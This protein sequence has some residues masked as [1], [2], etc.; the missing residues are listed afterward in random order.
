MIIDSKEAFERYETNGRTFMQKKYQ[1]IILEAGGRLPRT[2]SGRSR[3][4]YKTSVLDRLAREDKLGTKAYKAILNL[5]AKK[6]NHKKE[7]L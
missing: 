6:E 7:Q 1:D 5:D 2:G 4:L 3:H